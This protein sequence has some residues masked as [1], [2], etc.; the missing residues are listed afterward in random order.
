MELESN[1][2]VK[3]VAAPLTVFNQIFL[4]TSNHQ[5]ETLEDHLVHFC[6]VSGFQLDSRR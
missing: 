2:K 1:A 4:M 5:R 6:P 3:P